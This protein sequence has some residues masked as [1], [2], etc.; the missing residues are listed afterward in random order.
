MAVEM[1][2]FLQGTAAELHQVLSCH[3]HHACV[4]LRLGVSWLDKDVLILWSVNGQSGSEA[5]VNSY[6]SE[7]VFKHV[8]ATAIPDYRGSILASISVLAAADSWNCP[9]L[10]LGMVR[11]T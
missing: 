4:C 1:A 3:P 5:F 10:L 6:V 2:R 9:L 7:H 11:S 8:K